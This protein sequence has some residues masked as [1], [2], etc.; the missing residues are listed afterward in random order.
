MIKADERSSK[1]KILKKVRKGLLQKGDP[2]TLHLD[3]DTDVY[4]QESGDLVEVFSG[5][6]NANRGYFSY[7]FNEYDFIDQ[8]LVLAEEK[9]WKSVISLEKY[10]QSLL[11]HC[12]YILLKQKD[13]V[14]VAD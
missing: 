1:E 8:F 6:F 12:D 13:E 2:Y 14:R 10:F 5:N 4:V 7:C 11:A 3:L 9:R